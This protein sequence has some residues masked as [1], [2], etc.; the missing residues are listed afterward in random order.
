[1]KI[2]CKWLQEYVDFDWDWRELVDRLTMSGLEMESVDDLGERLQGLVV[3]HVKSV[4]SHPNA[5]RLSVCNVDL[6]DG[7]HTIVCGAPNV[8]AGQSVPVAP[9]GTRLPDGTQIRRAKIRGVESA[10]MIC[11]ETELGLGDDA[12]GIMVLAEGSRAGA[13]LAV[14]LGLDDT[15]VDFEVT[16]NRP[17]CLSLLGIAREVR[18][19]SGAVLRPPSYEVEESG[20]AVANAA[21]VEIEDFEGCPRYCARLIRGVRIGPSPAWLRNRLLALGQRSINNVVDI[22]NYVMLELGHPLHA[23]DLARLADQRIVVRRARSGESLQTLDGTEHELTDEVLVIADAERPVALAGI[24]GGANSEVGEDTVDILLE[25]A[26]FDPSRVRRGAALVQSQ[27]EAS[28]RFE[29]GA[30]WEMAPRACTRAAAL[31]AEITGG[32]VAPGILDA[33]P[34]PLSPPLV[35]MRPSR[36]AA[37]LG[38]ADLTAAECQR[39][40]ELLGCSVEVSGDQLEVRVPSFRPDLEREADLIEEVGRVYGYD[41][42]SSTDRLAGPISASHSSGYLSAAEA[43]RRLT[44]LGADE[45][46][47]STIVERRWMDQFGDPEREPWVLANPP[48]EGQDRLRTT[49]LPSLLEVARRNFNQRASEVCIFELGKRF[50]NHATGGPT[51]ETALAGLW[52]G[53][54]TESPWRR[55]QV[56]VD[57]LDIKGLVESLLRDLNLRFTPREHQLLRP[58]HGAAVS[59]DGVEIGFLGELSSGARDVFDLANPLF[60]FEFAFAQVAEAWQRRERGYLPLPKF[61][62]IERDLALILADSVGAGE[63]AADIRAVEPGLIESVEL[64]DTYKGSQLADG[65][66]SLAFSLRL[67]AGDKTL[68]DRQADEVMA[69][70]VAHLEEAFGARQR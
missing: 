42:I 41:R 63:V 1:M 14:A 34:R 16:P 40:L 22:T 54:R 52:S 13:G 43:R 9:P 12:S 66:K 2:T 8:A 15:A 38:S 67:R 68:E 59:L 56:P 19:L 65:E 48:T 37:L 49:L 29:R 24:M 7:E 60:I 20:D 6:G 17:D 64:F 51:E 39:I 26:Y 3:G 28:S 25:S 10:G 35:Q 36:A 69:R 31:I 62:P 27:T 58:G 53:L 4:E 50:Y 18:A 33:Y 61:P 57:F 47:T 21:S 5:D 70:V 30:D 44:G 46:V 32:A 55:E 23:F 11:S 45:V